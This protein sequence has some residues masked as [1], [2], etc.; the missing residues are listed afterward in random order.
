MLTIGKTIIDIGYFSILVLLFMVISS[1]LGMEFF[2][3][4]IKY[5]GLRILFD[6]FGNAMVAIFVLLTGENWNSI[7]FTYMYVSDSW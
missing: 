4:R 6:T 2:A 7:T 3:Y 1:L 5:D